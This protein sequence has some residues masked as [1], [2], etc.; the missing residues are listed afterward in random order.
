M[1]GSADS[2]TAAELNT[3]TTEA[4]NHPIYD[5]TELAALEAK[6]LAYQK[7]THSI[8]RI[9]TAM[10]LLHIPGTIV[11]VRIFEISKYLT[12]KCWL[13]PSYGYF[14]NMES[15][16]TEIVE[17]DGK[18]V[19]IFATL[20]PV[21]PVLAAKSYN[22]LTPIWGET[23]CK[24][25][26]ITNRIYFFIDID[27]HKAIKDTSATDTEKA[28]V[29][30]L[31]QYIHSYLKG[32]GWPE[33][34]IIDS[35]NGYYLIYRVDLPNDEES[36]TIL[37]SILLLLGDKFNAVDTSDD[38]VPDPKSLGKVDP[39][40]ANASRIFKVP[41]TMNCK[42]D[43]LTR[44]HPYI[45]ET[46]NEP[47]P[48]RRSSIISTPKVL[49]TVPRELLVTLASTYVTPKSK[50]T[51]PTPNQPIPPSTQPNNPPGNLVMKRARAYLAKMPPS[52]SGEHGH[53]RLYNVG[54]VLMDGYGFLRDD[55]KTLFQE[56]N[57]RADCDPETDAQLEHKLDDVEKEIEK[58]GGPSRNI[59]LKEPLEQTTTKQTSTQGP[60]KTSAKPNIP[61]T[62]PAWL[63]AR[64]L[65]TN[66]MFHDC[67]ILHHWGGVWWH[68]DNTAYKEI[69]ASIIEN[70]I[71][72]TA[73]TI[74]EEANIKALVAWNLAQ[75][76]P[77]AKPTDPPALLPVT[78]N[79]IS[80]I[81]ISLRAH[82][83]L[84][85]IECFP[86]WL[87]NTPPPFPLDNILP[88]KT[89]LVDLLTGE[90][91]EPT[92]NY[93][94]PYALDFEYDKSAPAPTNWL[95]FLDSIWGPDLESINL[96]QEWF[97]Y[98]L[99]PST[100]RQ[101][102]LLIIGPT[103]SG[104]GT[105]ARILTSLI[106]ASNIVGPTMQ[107]LSGEFGLQPLI[108][109]TL[110]IIGDARLGPKTDRS[111]ITERLL[112]ISGEDRL[113]INRK[114][115]TTWTGILPTRIVM[116]SNESPWLTDTSQALA[117]RFIILNQV[118]SFL[119]SEDMELEARLNT[120]LP[121]ILN[122][123]ISGWSRL[124][125]QREFTTP[126]SSAEMT[127]E[128]KDLS[129]RAS[130]FLNDACIT[131]PERSETIGNT[132]NA[133]LHWCNIHGEVNPG[134][135]RSLS[136]ELRVALPSISTGKTRKEGEGVNA[137]NVKLFTGLC[138]NTQYKALAAL[139]HP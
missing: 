94:A 65:E 130:I 66:Y 134:S 129:S 60:T 17:F 32:L 22:K 88:T 111:I 113:T 14:N 57:N 7:L 25:E 74:F 138:L 132:Y 46:H 59:V 53:D 52:I 50:S 79:L 84:D 10:I 56:Y 24:D 61:I 20:N 63:A 93:F 28:K 139:G 42:G 135:T 21:S 49:E 51:Q 23:A 96:L 12:D 55:A 127:Q 58:N 83:N 81:I 69:E 6:K 16:A 44:T 102:I 37:H 91:Q 104:K 122:W 101:K 48:W 26:N 100:H 117:N 98:C 45:I 112:A 67:P 2:E 125:K 35:G 95:A 75:S 126:A 106:G 33:P 105:I 73:E 116:L 19:G 108:G 54:M 90:T 68:W 82:T 85:T 124:N 114:H 119:G 87:G 89:A 29:F 4:R 40:V 118:K 62:N 99:T 109:K 133:W 43:N 115:T 72:T 15:L 110:A 120:E 107:G 34:I 92:P 121:S 136:K 70:T 41:G 8:D 9:Y 13:K 18:A 137:K 36:Y 27:P 1:F 64:T 77:G 38:E 39:K 123:A 11:E 86:A 76:K 97:G 78:R 131:G 128:I 3:S 80:N 31:Q 103:R 5:E 71:C 47:R 30:V